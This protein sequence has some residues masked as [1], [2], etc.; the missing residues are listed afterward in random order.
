MAEGQKYSSRH[1]VKTLSGTDL[2][3][4]SNA[5][6]NWRKL[7]R[8]QLDR[9]RWTQL[10]TR[11]LIFN[12]SLFSVKGIR[13]IRNAAV[14]AAELTVRFMEAIDSPRAVLH[15]GDGD[16]IAAVLCQVVY[17]ANFNGPVHESQLYLAV[18]R[19]KRLLD[20]M[21]SKGLSAT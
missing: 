16:K 10:V 18:S 2:A 19:V 4:Q 7:F 3:G 17:I 20:S 6:R 1:F 15:M 12:L 13:R 8:S 11:L 14:Q 9:P 5:L 21:R